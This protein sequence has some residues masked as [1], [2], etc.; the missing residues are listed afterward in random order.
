MSEKS[1]QQVMSELGQL[2]DFMKE[3]VEAFFDL[4]VEEFEN[5]DYDQKRGIEAIFKGKDSEKKV[6]RYYLQVLPGKGDP[7]VRPI[8]D[9]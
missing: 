9:D 3:Q 8:E 1:Y 7:I 6:K 2:E 5:Y 4:T